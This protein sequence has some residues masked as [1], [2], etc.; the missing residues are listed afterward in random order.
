VI[1]KHSGAAAI[2]HVLGTQGIPVE[3]AVARQLVPAVRNLAQRTRQAIQ[4]RDLAALYRA[5]VRS[6]PPCAS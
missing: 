3:R 5:H 6:L 2:R 4:P 1:G